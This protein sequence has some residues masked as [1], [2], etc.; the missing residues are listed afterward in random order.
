[1]NNYKKY[2]IYSL[3]LISITFF[4]YY[5]YLFFTSIVLYFIN[6]IRALIIT[7]R[8][9]L[10]FHFLIFFSINILFYIV[11]FI[12]FIDEIIKEKVYN[13]IR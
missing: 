4:A 6:I 13:K 7:S 3:I 2:L 5:I 8:F 12:M 11:G 10:S 9:F 1:M